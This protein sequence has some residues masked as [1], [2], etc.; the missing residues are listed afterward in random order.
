MVS[1]PYSKGVARVDEIESYLP[2]ALKQMAD[3]LKA[4]GTYEL[5]LRDVSQ[6]E[7]GALTEEFAGVLRKLEEGEN[8]EN[9]LMTLPESVDSRLMARTI[10]IIIDSIKA[11]AGLADVLEDIAEDVREAKRIDVER[12]TRTMMQVLFMFATGA[13]VAPFIFGIVSGLISLFI[14]S[15][16]GFEM[17]AAA[18]TKAVGAGA[19]IVLMLQIY[20]FIEIFASSLMIALMREGKASK[21]LSLFPLLLLVAFIVFF[22]SRIV[23][24]LM[25]AGG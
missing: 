7:Y 2:D 9:A 13:V 22:G 15:A 17:P 16:T 21:A 5:A 25:L 8:F 24:T 6:G 19:H 20:I 14:R 1:Y 23:A 12:R 10:N 4:G 11:G 3:T 18:I